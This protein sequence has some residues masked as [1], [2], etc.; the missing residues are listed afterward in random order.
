[1]RAREALRRAGSRRRLKGAL[2]KAG[3]PPGV[4]TGRGLVA[5]GL[6]AGQTVTERQSL[7][8][9]AGPETARLAT[10]LGPPIEEIER[11]EATPLLALDLHALHGFAP[12]PEPLRAPQGTACTCWA[13]VPRLTGP[14][15]GTSLHACLA[16]LDAAPGPGRLPDAV[17]EAVPDGTGGLAVVWADGARTRISSGPVRVTR[18][19]G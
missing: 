2:E 7:D 16:A 15:G 8:D 1:M 18:Q 4:W 11:R 3:L 6:T 17:T 9:G 13:E 12:A 19:A 5:L 10:V 14:T